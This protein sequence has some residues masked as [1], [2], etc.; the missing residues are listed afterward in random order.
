VP[1][2][3]VGELRHPIN[4]HWRHSSMS[5]AAPNV[6]IAASGF[7][8]A[9]VLD[10]GAADLWLGR[11]D[12]EGPDCFFTSFSEVSSTYIGDSC[13][14]L[15]FFWVLCN[16]VHLHCLDINLSFQ[17]LRGSSCSKKI[18]CFFQVAASYK[19]LSLLL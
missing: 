12:R 1:F 10:S 11:G 5:A 13:F 7:V 4:L 18:P 16:N 9:A 19:F 3:N 8:P 6:D 17:V 15:S 14:T 2:V